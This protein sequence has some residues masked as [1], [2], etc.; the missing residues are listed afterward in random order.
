MKKQK[1]NTRLAKNVFKRL[2]KK[3]DLSD[4][5]SQA[6][7]LAADAQLELKN[8]SATEQNKKNN[9]IFQIVDFFSGA[10]GMSA[11][12]AALSKKYPVF[13]MIGGVDINPNAART[14]EKNF[15]V[16]GI[17]QDVTKLIEKKS[18]SEFVKKLDRYDKTKPLIVLGCAPCQGFSAHR[19]KYKDKEDKRNDLPA[20]FASVAVKLNPECIVMENVPEILSKKYWNYFEDV[21]SIFSD[22]GYIVNQ[23]IYN[24]AAFG[25]PQ[26]RYRALII[27]MKKK[28]TMPEPLL[29]KSS[30]LTVKDAIGHLPKVEAGEVYLKDAYHVSAKHKPSTI[31]VIKQIPKN[32]GSR[33][34]GIGPKCLDRVKGFYDVYGRLSWDKP[35][36][37]ITQ[38][39]RN[40]AS[41]RYVHPD[42]DRGLT[43]REAASIQSFPLGFEFT[44][45]FDSIFKQIGEAVPPK[46]GCAVAASVI[47]ELLSGPPKEER[48]TVARKEVVLPLLRLRKK[49]AYPY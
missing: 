47:T 1:I 38:Y 46:L 24:A 34:K 5:R 18:F 30:Y 28:F 23:G 48:K 31:D 13:R 45:N 41:G 19:K 42:Q 10:G 44:G 35:S 12:F 29:E 40:P 32:G 6:K 7:Q 9:E 26:E 27:A 20:I 39:A 25:V 8:W 4:F 11:G 36:I 3:A 17:I 37:T 16:P 43:I 22:A 21:R 2:L 14:Y 15:K 49:S 33:P